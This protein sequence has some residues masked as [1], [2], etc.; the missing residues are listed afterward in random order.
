VRNLIRGE[1]IKMRSTRTALGFTIAG[2]LLTL[3]FVLVSTLA[4]DPSTLDDKRDALSVFHLFILF[5][6]FGVVGATGEYRHRTVAPAVLIAPDRLRLLGARALAYAVTAAGVAAVMMVVSFAVGIPLMAGNEGASLDFADYA[7]LVGGTLLGAALG[8]ALGVG[9]GALVGNQVAGVVSI[10][11]YLFVVDGL[12]GVA[13]SDLI[14]WTLG[15]AAPA[16]GGIEIEEAFGFAGSLGV[17]ALWTAV[18]VGAGMARE[19][20]REV[21]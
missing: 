14:P 3:M 21:T 20:G 1:A 8:S 5:V 18:F 7:G 2:A 15:T 11:L 19:S 6:V 10:L 9:F 13:D 4:G 17:M 12:I 16:L